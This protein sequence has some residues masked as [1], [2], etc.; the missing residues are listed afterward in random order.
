MEARRRTGLLWRASCGES[1]GASPV[2]ES[3]HLCFTGAVNEEPVEDTQVEV[4]SYFVR[5]RN[6]LA[7]RA[8]LGPIYVDHYLHLMQHGMR[9]E[10]DIDQILKDALGA[11]TLHLAARPWDEDTAWTINFQDPLFNLF[12]TGNSR[13]E[14]VTGRAFTKDVKAGGKNRMIAQLRDDRAGTRQSFVEFHGT[15][16]F[17]ILEQFFVQSEQ[18]L[19]RLFRHTDENFVMLT[20]QPDCDEDWLRSL[21]DEDIRQLDQTEDLSLLESRFYRF[22]CGCDLDRILPTMASLTAPLIEELY[23]DTEVITIQCPR[24]GARFPL[25][26]VTLEEYLKSS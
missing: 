26:R 24:C 21:T 20:A 23:E 7:T 13:L 15:D 16:F 12:V 8:D 2:A 22:G 1:L 18:R 10:P 3:V 19:A 5:N 25:S 17:S 4:R 14:N 11:L 6:A 9:L